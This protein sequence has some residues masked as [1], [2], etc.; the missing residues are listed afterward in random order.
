M[1]EVG[2]GAPGVPPV[3]ILT[4][5][6]VTF[7]VATFCATAPSPLAAPPTLGMPIALLILLFTFLPSSLL[8]I[9]NAF[10]PK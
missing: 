6:A 1:G 9:F 5:P 8:P 7:I 4:T 10:M 3:A 2:A